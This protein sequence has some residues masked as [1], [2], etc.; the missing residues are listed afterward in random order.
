MPVSRRIIV[1]RF[2]IRDVTP[3]LLV[4]G[5]HAR[6]PPAVR[7]VMAHGRTLNPMSVRVIIAALF[8]RCWLAIGFIISVGR[9]GDPVSVSVII[10]AA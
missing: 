4:P 10:S 9:H 8:G 7:I 6:D 3:V 2:G 1:T 5:R